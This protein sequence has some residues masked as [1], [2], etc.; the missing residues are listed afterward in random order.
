LVPEEKILTTRWLR[1][2]FLVAITLVAVWTLWRLVF[3][4]R[5]GFPQP[6]VHDEFSYLLGADTFIHGRLANPPHPLAAFF[7]SPHELMRPVYASKY[8]PGQAMFLALG[9][10][11]LGAPFYGVLIGDALMLFTFCLMLFAWVP[12]RAAI[13]VTVFFALILS[14]V[15]D[16][17][18]SYWGGAVAA[19]GAALVLLAVGQFRRR[20]TPL[21]GAVFAAGLLLL[22]WTRPYEGG[23]FALAVLAVFARTIWRNR[24]IAM[25][26]VAAVVLAAGGAWSCYYNESITGH[27]FLLP[28]VLH[29]RQYDV[30]PVFWFLPL[31]PQPEYDHPRLAAQY[32]TNGSEASVYRWNMLP[33]WQRPVIG[34]MRVLW[35]LDPL[36]GLALLLVILVPIA[37]RD[38]LFV[39]MFIVALMVLAALTL[40]T[41]QGEHYSAPGW[42]AV[43]LMI[44]IWTERALHAENLKSPPRVVLGLLLLVWLGQSAFRLARVQYRVMK[45]GYTVCYPDDWPSQRAALIRRLSALGRPQLVI[46]RYPTPDWNVFEEWVYNSADIDHQ[47]VVFAHDLGPEK[48]KSLL[49]YYHDREPLLLT[50]DSISRKAEVRPYF[51]AN[52]QPE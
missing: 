11:I 27:P 30:V 31:G 37:W 20:Q 35:T 10:V 19:S 13:I 33:W 25:F 17:T 49:Q 1:K 16:W 29:Q 4:W 32:G 12:P 24:R 40:E 21:S 26:S 39:K 41:F 47:R 51:E 14:P 6:R 3:L 18:D 36:L 48:D 15:M 2:P 8:P 22:F 34:A 5:A 44:A 7:E 52:A 28:Y 23:V 43:A 46:V 45:D 38:P 42:A 50:F 9:Q